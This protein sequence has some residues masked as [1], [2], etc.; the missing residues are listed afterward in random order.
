M[1]CSRCSNPSWDIK[2]QTFGKFVSWQIILKFSKLWKNKNEKKKNE[3]EK[4]VSQKLEKKLRNFTQAPST[5]PSHFIYVI[6]FTSHWLFLHFWSLHCHLDTFLYLF[7]NFSKLFHY[8][9][10]WNCRH[11]VIISYNAVVLLIYWT[12]MNHTVIYR[13]CYCFLYFCIRHK[14]YF[15][16]TIV[17]VVTNTRP[18][19]H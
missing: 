8:F 4:I 6:E 15:S 7:R 19:Y 12:C 9:T 13:D 17:C 10:L 18:C 16:V 2:S 5:F 3:K 14:V 1:S 11:F